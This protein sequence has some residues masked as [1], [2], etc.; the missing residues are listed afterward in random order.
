MKCH[1][2]NININFKQKRN[3]WWAGDK[4]FKKIRFT[5]MPLFEGIIPLHCSRKGS[6]REHKN[7]RVMPR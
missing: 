2:L 5:G 3:K 4:E 7:S 6:S 1:L